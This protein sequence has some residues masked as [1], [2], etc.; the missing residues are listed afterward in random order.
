MSFT[1]KASKHQAELTVNKLFA[2]ILH[3]QPT[4][5]SS[6]TKDNAKLSSTQILTNQLHPTH[7]TTSKAKSQK[8]R[9]L[10]KVKKKE[11]ED[12]KFQKFIKYNHI[13]SKDPSQQ[14]DADKAYIRK[15]VRKNTNQVKNLSHIDDFEVESELD[16]VKSQLL[17]D[18]QPKSKSRLRKRLVVPRSSKGDADGVSKQEFIDFDDKV[19]RGL[20]SVPG[21]TPGLAPV[22]ENESESDTE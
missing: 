8:K 1:S 5:S 19:Q 21:L 3:T 12:K 10:Q 14:T 4:T 17:T 2:D 15:L 11:I 9:K 18:L 13:L 22:D 6:T 7:S 16:M 20:I